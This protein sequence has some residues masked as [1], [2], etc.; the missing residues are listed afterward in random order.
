MTS[1]GL[2]LFLGWLCPSQV[3]TD[4]LLGEGLSCWSEVISR[5]SLVP[6]EGQ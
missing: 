6:S 3:I 4:Y 2:H 1:M 5:T